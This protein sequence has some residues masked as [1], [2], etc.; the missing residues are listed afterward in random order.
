[1]LGEIQESRSHPLCF[2]NADR[3]APSAIAFTRP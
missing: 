1:L 3:R 2:E